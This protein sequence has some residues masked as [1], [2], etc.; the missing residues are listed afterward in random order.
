LAENTY[1]EVMC[2]GRILVRCGPLESSSADG[3]QCTFK[4]VDVA[5]TIRDARNWLAPSQT[6]FLHTSTETDE[7]VGALSVLPTAPMSPDAVLTQ[8]RI[9]FSRVA[10]G[11]RANEMA[12]NNEATGFKFAGAIDAWLAKNR[13]VDLKRIQVRAKASTFHP[14]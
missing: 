3:L 2:A 5:F 14:T 6:L 1:A 13:H 12:G 4:Q 7:S 8:L 11:L 10:Q 9:I